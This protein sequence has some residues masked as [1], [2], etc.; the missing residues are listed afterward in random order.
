MCPLLS[1][2]GCP[3][4]P[5]AEIEASR[6]RI[7]GCR[8]SSS[9]R[10][11]CNVAIAILATTVSFRL[12]KTS[13]SSLKVL[14]RKVRSSIFAIRS[15]LDLLKFW[16]SRVSFSFLFSSSL[17]S[18]LKCSFSVFSSSMLDSSFIISTF[19]DRTCSVLCFSVAFSFF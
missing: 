6:S 12:V 3:E 15:W 18:V 10:S 11:H 13:L 1:R 14:F 4:L 19:I 2:R 7:S 5:Q 16:F 8:C 17:V 9:R